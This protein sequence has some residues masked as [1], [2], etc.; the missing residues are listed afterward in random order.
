MITFALLFMNVEK[1]HPDFLSLCMGSM[2]YVNGGLIGIFTVFTFFPARMSGVGLV[3]G[4]ATG[5]LTTTLCE[6]AFAAP[7]PWTYTVILSSTLSFLA[8]ILGGVLRKE[9]VCANM[10]EANRMPGEER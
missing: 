4:L 3:L 10:I 6:W 1:R 2:N 8:C 7:V 9:S 5:F